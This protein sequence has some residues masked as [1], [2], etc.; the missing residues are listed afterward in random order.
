MTSVPYWDGKVTTAG[1]YISK[2]EAMMEYHDNGDAMDENAI[3]TCP[4][5]TEYEAIKNSTDAN[6]MKLVKLYQQNKKACA[7]IVMGQKSN[8][9]L[10]MINK[11]KTDDHPH[12]IAWKA[13]ATMKRKNKPKDMSAEIEMEAELHKIQFRT[14]IDYYNDVVAVTS[15]YEVKKSDTDLIKIMSTKVTSAMYAAMIL[16][17][18]ED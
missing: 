18:M 16:S 3:A 12:G 13:I 11:T 8:H 15:N 5:K 10:A 6:E 7:I 1:M 14:A 4:T 9:G 2:V 17:H